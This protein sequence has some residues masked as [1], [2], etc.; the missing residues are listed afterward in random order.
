[1]TT[2]AY[3][4][5]LDWTSRQIAPGKPGA[6]PAAIP[7]LFERLKIE[8]KAWHVLVTQFETLFSLVA[9]QPQRVDAYR[10]RLR[11]QRYQL[12]KHTRELL[13]A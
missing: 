12:P 7:S 11:Q 1:M 10:S 2:A 9:G 6:T 3:L 5:L 13:S 8:P 4:D